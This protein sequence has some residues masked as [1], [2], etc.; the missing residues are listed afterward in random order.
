MKAER[1]QKEPQKANPIQSKRER[2]KLSFVDNRPQASS[3]EILIKSIQKKENAIDLPYN[4][5]NN[6]S[7][8]L[9]QRKIGIIQES[10]TTFKSLEEL[11]SWLKLVG[12]DLAEKL[13]IIA[14]IM[15]DSDRE[16]IYQQDKQ[17]GVF[18]FLTKI[19]QTSSDLLKGR[20]KDVYHEN[21]YK[22]LIQFDNYDAIPLDKLLGYAFHGDG[23]VE[24][25]S[26]IKEY[27]QKIV[28]A[29]NKKEL[30]I[31]LSQDN[32]WKLFIDGNQQ[33]HGKY[34]FDNEQD[35]LLNMYK[36]FFTTLDDNFELNSQTYEELNKKA[37]GGGVG[38]KEENKPN[39][40][41]LVMGNNTSKNG[42]EEY[43]KKS[44]IADKTFNDPEYTFDKFHKQTSLKDFCDA[45][46]A[47]YSNIKENRLISS[48]MNASEI[49][50]FIFDKWKTFG[51]KKSIL[52]MVI[53]CQT[54]DQ[55]HLFIDG[56]IRT[57]VF[58][59]LNK[60]LID[61]GYPLVTFDNPN[62]FDM[63]S[64]DQIT[65]IIA[66]KISDK[67]LKQYNYNIPDG[68]YNPYKDG[69]LNVPYNPYEDEEPTE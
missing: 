18:G 67:L 69:A 59:V 6:I 63:Y 42:L 27:E 64:V 39:H 29:L 65:G 52:D 16:F 7:P 19:S 15:I 48:G 37:L 5:D 25:E 22:Y 57:I 28:V 66:S 31:N 10:N 2:S 20:A 54:L 55:L 49:A 53:V 51:D 13:K 47:Y 45:L 9:C 23:F 46:V 1:Q 14:T 33:E 58:V 44:I 50:D 68:I 17:L 32:I 3:Q 43:N 56:N 12:I 11:C 4:S 40:F 35:Y 8:K 60:M 26:Q 21:L 41:G 34:W 24:Y 38:Y 62:I 36:S 61:A 30:Q